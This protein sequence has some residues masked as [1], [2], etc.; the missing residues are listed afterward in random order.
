MNA[1][2]ASAGDTARGAIDCDVPAAAFISFILVAHG[3]T[4]ACQSTSWKHESQYLKRVRHTSKMTLRR[5]VI[6]VG[7]AGS[8]LG[9][10]GFESF[11]FGVC[12]AQRHTF[13]AAITANSSFVQ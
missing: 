5:W 4:T 11:R 12:V 2:V 9:P 13:F 7:I 8:G 3:D 6:V 10:Q 1:T